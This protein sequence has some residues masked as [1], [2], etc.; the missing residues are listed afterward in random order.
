MASSSNPESKDGYDIF[1]SFRG[2]D[3]RKNF[4]DHLYE[5]L[6]QNEFQTFRD[7]DEIERG[8]NIKSE[9]QKA[10]WNSR[11]SIV[12][13]SKNNSTACLF[14]IQTILE[15][16]QKKSDHFILPVF[17]EV[18]PTEIK[19]QAKILDFGEKK[20]VEQVKGWSAALK[21]VASMAGMVSKN[22][23][24]GFEAKFIKE[25]VGE[26]K[27]KLAGK[28][29]SFVDHQEL[30][31]NMRNLKRKVEYLSGQENDTKAEIS[32]AGSQPSKR[33]KKEVEVWLRDVQLLKDD[34]QRLEQEVV[35]E[36]SLSSRAL[37]GKRIVEKS[38][39]V[40][41]LQEKGRVFNGLVIDELPTGRL[42]IPPT[43]DFVEST[44]ARNTENV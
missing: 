12:V 1:L 2:A 30:G 35:G 32:S 8:E 14:E 22:Q 42:L 10:I 23:C 7:D 16:R 24:D 29:Q 13:L 21:E 28:H 17:Y 4:T 26:V 43:K 38:Q 40:T 6:K 15:H 19:R 41:E 27:S 31:T 18:D 11:M 37:L 9:L 36:M 20:T 5:A 3:T 33:P 25:I 34:V 44:K 39:E